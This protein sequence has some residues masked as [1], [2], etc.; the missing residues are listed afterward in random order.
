MKSAFLSKL[1]MEI[2]NQTK[3]KLEKLE[4]KT[5][6]RNSAQLRIV[7]FLNHLV[8]SWDI[9][10]VHTIKKTLAYNFIW[11]GGGG[12]S[13]VWYRCSLHRSDAGKSSGSMFREWTGRKMV[14][15]L[16]DVICRHYNSCGCQQFCPVVFY[17]K[18]KK[19]F[20]FFHKK[21]QYVAVFAVEQTF[22]GC[23]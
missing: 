16:Q 10:R 19:N 2:W 17:R 7:P 21:R 14:P 8:V 3:A 9:N 15:L 6:S 23:P 13:S 12:D 18:R 11:G 22:S 4:Q 20:Y 1:Q 5:S